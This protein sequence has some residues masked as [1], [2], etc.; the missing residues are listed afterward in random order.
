M[1]NYNTQ[2]FPSSHKREFLKKNLIYNANFQDLSGDINNQRYQNTFN[3]IPANSEEMF[4]LSLKK[5][6]IKQN[7][8]YNFNFNENSNIKNRN[9][10]SLE[11][12]KNLF[13]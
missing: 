1:N 10:S 7:H 11:V 3:E 6:N 13:S 5:S 9:E 12:N 2:I 4:N 8:V